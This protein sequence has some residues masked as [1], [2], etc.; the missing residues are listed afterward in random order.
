MLP[1]VLEPEVM[2]TPEEARAYDAMDFSA[3]NAAFVADLLAALDPSGFVP[4]QNRSV[5]D[6][7]TGTARIPLE[8]FRQVAWGWVTAI[9][10]SPAMLEIARENVAAAG[11]A[12]R[13]TLRQTTSTPLVQAGERFDVVISNS[14][15]HHVADAAGLLEELARL[16]AP[17]GV[18]FVRDLMRPTSNQAIEDLVL[19]HAGGDT[20]HQQQLFRQSLAAALTLGEVREIA[21]ELPFET[22][23]ELTSDRHWTL[24]GRRPSGI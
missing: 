12:E 2:E 7:G 4:Q 15:V 16:V 5:L 21:S 13:I 10:L 3:V 11:A 8:F 14:L 6:V 24:V 1:R 22:I 20:P 9:D 19:L 17:G 23:V 18:L